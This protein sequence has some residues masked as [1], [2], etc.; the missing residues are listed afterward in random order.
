MPVYTE[1]KRDYGPSGIGEVR[2]LKNDVKIITVEGVVYLIDNENVPEW[3]IR[4]NQKEA[5]YRISSDETKLSSVGPVGDSHIVEFEAFTPRNADTEEPEARVTK[6]GQRRD[7]TSTYYV[8]DRSMFNARLK[9]VVGDFKDYNLFYK[10][11]YLFAIA[12]DGSTKISIRPP[13]RPGWATR[14]EEFFRLAGFD[15]SV[16][17]IPFSPNVLPWLENELQGRAESSRFQAAVTDGRVPWDGL[18]SLP[19]G[20]TV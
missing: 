17:D 18:N 14:L 12:D 11:D 5:W 10:M 7:G 6:G 19:T 2:F 15:F 20:V 4:K 16:E 3:V 8:P 13:Q 1:V 9:I